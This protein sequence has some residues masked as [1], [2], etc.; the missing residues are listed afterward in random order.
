M[1]QATSAFIGD[2]RFLTPEEAAEFLDSL[3]EDEFAAEAAN[4]TEYDPEYND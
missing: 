2:V 4:R 3:R 1:M